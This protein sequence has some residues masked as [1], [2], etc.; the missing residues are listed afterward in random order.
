MGGVIEL[1]LQIESLAAGGR[2]VARHEGKVWFVRGGL[3]GDRVRARVEREQ[4]RFVEAVAVER[5]ADG[6]D[7]RPAPCAVQQ[8]CGGCPWM[9]LPIDLQRA[10]K[11]RLVT[12]ALARIGGLGTLAVEPVRGGE[13]ELAYRDRIELRARHDGDAWS[14]G[15]SGADGEIVDVATCPLQHADGDRVLRA[16]RDELDRGIR[17]RGGSRI[18]I[19][20][21]AGGELLLGWESGFLPPGDERILAETLLERV[22]GLVG[23]VRI[24]R[25]GKGRG[26]TRVEALA[27]KRTLT[28]RISGVTVELPA[29]TFAQVNAEV[30]AAMT[31]HVVD[32]LQLT[33][34]LG[35]WDLYG[36]IG[37]YAIAIATAGAAV[38]V[39]E[40]DA[41]AVEAG[42]RACSALDV[43]Y[44]RVTVER[45]LDAPARRPDRLVANPPRGGMGAKTVRRLAAQAIARWVLV[46]CDP[47]TLARDLAAAVA[48]GYRVE[49]VVPFDMFPQSAHV[50]CVVTLVRPEGS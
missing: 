46:S 38:L 48:C 50:E 28:E 1:E 15:Y 43:T 17:S 19:R 16:F 36:G 41:E 20:R 47:A 7:R 9:P 2:G 24:D 21:S 34:G 18:L 25:P 32:E 33:E 26:G 14:V 13:L 45:F 27:G 42:R 23:V 3:P 6:P 8:R 29:A 39:C 12:D 49:R 5:L 30:A 22:D 44:A 11:H 37:S 4:A 31:R 40:A 35:V 10:A